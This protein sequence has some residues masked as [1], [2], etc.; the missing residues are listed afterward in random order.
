MK[1]EGN[2]DATHVSTCYVERQRL[3]DAFSKKF[4][5]HTHTVALYAV[6]YNF[7]R[8][9]KS[10]RV[11]PAIAAMISDRLWDEN[12]AALVETADT[13]PGKRRL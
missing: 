8:V 13:K 6:W 10:A 9:H 5:N 7:A 1:V 11:P 3:T 4:E 2:P 12:L